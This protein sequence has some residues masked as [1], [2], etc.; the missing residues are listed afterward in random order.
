LGK[1][2]IPYSS[3]QEERAIFSRPS[4]S[5]RKGSIEMPEDMIPPLTA[6]PPAVGRE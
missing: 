2:E 5:P 6:I 1:E 4:R 3:R